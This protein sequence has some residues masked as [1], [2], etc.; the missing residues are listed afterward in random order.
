MKNVL[1]QP[2]RAFHQFLV[3]SD[4]IHRKDQEYG[5]GHRECG[6]QVITAFREGRSTTLPPIEKNIQQG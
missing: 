1:P 5:D 6:A 2:V 3:L 4:A